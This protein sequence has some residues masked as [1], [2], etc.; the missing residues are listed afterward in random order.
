LSSAKNELGVIFAKSVAGATMIPI[1]WDSMMCPK[2]K[3]KEFRKVAK[4]PDFEMKEESN[5]K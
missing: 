5:N 2:T 1:S 4:L 3:M